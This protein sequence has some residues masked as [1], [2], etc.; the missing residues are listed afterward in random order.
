MLISRRLR[1]AAMM[2][3]LGAVIAATPASAKEPLRIGCSDWP[4]WTTWQI[5]VDKG[6]FKEAGVDV[7]MQWFDYSA[8][9]D[10]FTAGKL[11][12]DLCGTS[13][14]LSLGANGAR[15]TIILLTDYSNGNDMILGKPG[16]KDVRQ[17]AN[18]SVGIEV[19]VLEHLLLE[20]ALKQAGLQISAVKLVNAKTNETPQVLASGSVS[21]IGAWQPIAGQAMSLVPGARPIFTSAQAPGL[22]F[23]GLAVTPQSL[24]QRRDDWKKVVGVWY[25]ILAYIAD[26]K[27][28]DDALRIMAAR[29]GL[30]PGAYKRLVGGT[31]LLSRAE[32]RAAFRKGDTL[33]SLYGSD[34]NADDFN[35]RNN[36]YK[37]PQQIDMYIDP[38]LVE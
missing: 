29:D 22:I 38:S 14:A 10:A 3:L 23:D 15:N 8:S 32:A 36:V 4:G 17:L 18:Q 37:Q 7:Q 31:R 12:G 21:A 13:D 5:A 34:K 19:G 25:R 27:T 24:K 35:V 16:I 20:Y 30:D 6:W 26:P 11:D 33:M 9:L 1:Q 2:F 28:A